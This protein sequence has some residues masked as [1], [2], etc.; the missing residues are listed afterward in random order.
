[1]KKM[2]LA[3]MML[4][5]LLALTGCGSSDHG[6]PLTFR[7]EIFS[8]L[9]LDGD[10]VERSSGVYTVTQGAPSLLAGL[11]PVTVEEYRAFLGFPLTG[12]GGVPLNAIIVSATLNIVIDSIQPPN[13]TIP[14]RI[15]LVSFTPPLLGTD[16]DRI[17]LPQL[18][19]TAIKPP[20]SRFDVGT[21]VA[22]D[23]TSLMA[24]AQRLGLT[25]FQ[26]R[27]LEDFGIVDPGL[28]EIN[29]DTLPPLLQVVY[30]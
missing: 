3:A 28:I 23:V 17:L 14:I 26:I 16:F 1:M 27:I 9:A 5:I 25:D 30:F 15:E 19:A 4:S 11:D 2:L 21:N 22:V 6:A 13:G 24:E 12:V 20:I 29:D 10:I 7:T 18:A 8:D